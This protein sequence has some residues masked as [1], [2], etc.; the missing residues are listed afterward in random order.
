MEAWGR[1]RF[2]S[3]IPTEPAETCLYT[4]TPDNDYVLDRV[5][6]LVD[7]I[8][9][10]RARVQGEPDVGS[11]LADLATGTTPQRPARPV[12]RLPA[13]VARLTPLKFSTGRCR[14]LPREG[15][16]SS[17]GL[18]SATPTLSRRRFVRNA[19]VGTAV[20]GSAL[21]TNLL[22]ATPAAAA[23]VRLV[24]PAATPTSTCSGAPRGVRRP[25]SS[26]SIH[27]MGPDAWLDEQLHPA[28]STTRALAKRHRREASR[29]S[30]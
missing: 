14:Y 4:N 28:A 2:A 7:R 12:P 26:P 6:A 30:R 25:R 13:R 23:G 15:D 19:A 8:A 3:L 21:G 24:P 29:T 9:V 5:G 16:T 20:A 11:I 27:A 17:R 1:I 18:A 10:Q 22:R